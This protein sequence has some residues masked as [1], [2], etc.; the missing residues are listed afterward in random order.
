MRIRSLCTIPGVVVAGLL[1]GACQ[2]ETRVVR[3]NPFL[4]NIPGAETQVKPV[5]DRLGEYQDPT[6]VEGNRTILEN[7][8]GSV[9]LVAKSVRHLMSHIMLCLEYED[10]EVLFEQVISERTKQEFRG[11]GKD[12]IEAVEFLKNNRQD[13]ALLFARMP[14]GEQSPNIIL[15]QPAKRTVQLSL[16][17]LAAKDMRFTELWAVMEHGNWKLLWIR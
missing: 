5:G 6:V 16:T 9:T 1:V 12:P 3:Y 2:P 7:P 8:D 13:I 17:G 15:K 11:E 10:D 14:F 4:A